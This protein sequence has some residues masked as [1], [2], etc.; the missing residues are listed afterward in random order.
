MPLQ[1]CYRHMKKLVIF[2]LIICGILLLNAKLTHKGFFD[3]KALTYSNLTREPYK[4]PVKIPVR[5]TILYEPGNFMTFDT[6]ADEGDSAFNLIRTIAAIEKIDMETETTASGIVV[7]SINGV[8]NSTDG[9]WHYYVN[10]EM[11]N[12]DPDTRI[13][14][15]N[16][17][18]EW[19]FE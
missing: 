8:T 17:T 1:G 16:D 2:I 5:L 14:K 13:I 4:P 7:T 15:A 3:G 10:E 11:Q 9:T 6:E 18:V 19:R 12:I